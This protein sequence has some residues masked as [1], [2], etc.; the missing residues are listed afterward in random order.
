VVSY[1]NNWHDF[2]NIDSVSITLVFITIITLF[3]M[4]YNLLTFLKEKYLEDEGT[5]AM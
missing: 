4:V 1:T 3:C 5:V 2:T